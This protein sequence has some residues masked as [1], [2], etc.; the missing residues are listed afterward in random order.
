MKTT[1]ILIAL[2][3]ACTALSTTPSRAAVNWD[4]Q[5]PAAAGTW[6]EFAKEGL[7][8]DSAGN[9]YAIGYNNHLSPNGADAVILKRNLAGALVAAGVFHPVPGDS[10]WYT[11]VAVDASAGTLVVTGTHLNASTGR[12][13]CFAQRLNAATLAPVP[14]W[15]AARYFPPAALGRAGD[16]N[17]YGGRIAITGAGIF[18]SA[19]T[20]AS[21]AMIKV[22]ATTGIPSPSWPAAG[23]QPAGVRHTPGVLVPQHPAPGNTDGIYGKI[24]QTFVEIQGTN[25][26][27]AGSIDFGAGNGQD[28]QTNSYTQAAGVVNWTNTFTNG[29]KHELVKGTTATATGV[30]LVGDSNDGLADTIFLWGR[31]LGGGAMGGLPVFGPATSYSNDIEALATGGRDHIYI[32]SD[33]ASGGVVLHFENVG[34]TVA[35]SP[36]WPGVLYGT[37]AHEQVLDL[38]IG[39]AGAFINRVYGIGIHYDPTAAGQQAALITIQPSGAT[40]LT[41]SLFLQ[42]EAAGNAVLF[43]AARS[44]VFTS[45]DGVDFLGNAFAEQARFTP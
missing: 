12:S 16:A 42:D 45:G 18:I 41:P 35:A 4:F 40:T 1:S 26:I 9:T 22:A 31:T 2:A 36:T 32:A 17:S 13:E 38:A 24:S 23:P 11:G 20:D 37:G 14:G 7:A 10:Y 25:V 8:S 30:Y 33:Q 28:A 19:N 34:G 6:S 27:L 15:T 43:N 5:L 39:N 3:A 44:T 21:I 29:T